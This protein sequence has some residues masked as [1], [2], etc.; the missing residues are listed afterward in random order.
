MPLSAVR[1][2]ASKALS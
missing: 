2:Q 1:E